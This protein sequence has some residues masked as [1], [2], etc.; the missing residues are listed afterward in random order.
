MT[1]D[2]Y[3]NI[4]PVWDWTKLPG[5]TAIQGTLE[6]GESNPIGVHGET[7][8][9]GGVS[10][11]IYGMAAM[12]L[13]RGSLSAKKTWF[14]FDDGYLC[15]GAGITLTGN[16]HESVATDVNQTFLIGPVM[17]NHANGPLENGVYD[18]AAGNS[19]WISHD[20]VGYV[21]PSSSHVALSIGS[22]SGKWSEIGSGSDR[23]VT[24]PV[25][26]LWIDDG[27]SPREGT[28]EYIVLP[29]ATVRDTITYA[30][31]PW[32]QVLAN[33]EKIQAAWNKRLQIGMM[34][35]REAGSLTT[36]AGRITVDHSCLLMVSKDGESWK[37]TAA[38]PEN[39]P[40]VLHVTI[41]NRL[42]SVE[43]PGGNLA[44]SSITAH[45]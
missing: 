22:Q 27:A 24:A 17:T 34:A 8:F 20:N 4:F 39:L 14:F 23:I 43:L 1:G 10:D 18:Y 26:N 28:Y 41:G 9:D 5:T 32:I 29:G 19:I 31:R 2:E 7:A 13:H 38:N 40:L 37:I 12:D 3:K 25:F 16:A 11:G 21:F 15:L 44:G 42:V 6:T 35:F 36:P 45:L 33:S 30:K